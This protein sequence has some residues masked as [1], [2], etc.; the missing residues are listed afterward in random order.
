MTYGAHADTSAALGCVMLADPIKPWIVLGTRP[1]AIKLAPLFLAMRKMPQFKP[2][3]ISTGQHAS[4]VRDVLG[5]FDVTPDHDLAVMQPGQT[6]S[7]LTRNI[8]DAL[9]PLIA[10]HKPDWLVVQGDTTTTFVTS[11]VG[12]YHH[13][14]VAHV[15]AGLRTGDLMRPWPEEA[16][17]RLTTIVAG[18]HY[19][20]T[21]LARDNL[22]REGVDA[23]SVEVTGNTVIDA[24][25][26]VSDRLDRDKAAQARLAAR[27]PFIDPKRRMILVTGHRRESFGDGFRN[28][29]EA[30]ATLA[31]RPDVQIVYPVHLN[32]NV[33]D[34]VH[35]ALGGSP[36]IHLVPPADYEAFIY[37]MKCSHFILTDSG[38]V[39][40]EAPSLRRPVL[41]MRETSE[42]MEAVNAGVAKLVSTS[43]SGIVSS[44]TELLD[45]PSLYASMQSKNSP[46]GD[47]R[48]SQRIADSI[49]AATVRGAKAH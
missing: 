29:C 33:H 13:I 39:Q 3:L 11:L 8:I 17:R 48:A 43:V 16:N 26:S 20:P 41:V 18:R 30:I 4:M 14:P 2:V 9:D 7:L 40:E 22:L 37:L 38:G 27:F 15:E 31:R 34:T 32:P 36:N 24:L 12:F 47:G 45:N 5:A 46:F 19:P 1:E 35:K 21:T 10:Q 6:L 28:I 49:L 23:A 25:L 44:A 42:R